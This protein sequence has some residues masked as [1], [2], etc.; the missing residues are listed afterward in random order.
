ML[1]DNLLTQLPPT[2]FSGLDVLRYPDTLSLCRHTHS[3]TLRYVD[4]HTLSHSL[5]THSLSHSLDTHILS[6]SVDTLVDTLSD[7][8]SY[9]DTYSLALSRHTH[10]HTDNSH[11]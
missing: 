5:G 11:P 3:H 4:T 9:V 7:T 2:V 8:L 1:S 10:T 6:Y